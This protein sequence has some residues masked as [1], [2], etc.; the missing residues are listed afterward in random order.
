MILLVIPLGRSLFASNI[1]HVGRSVGDE[2]ISPNT[3][4]PLQPDAEQRRSR[5]RSR[6][7]YDLALGVESEAGKIDVTID[8]ST[9]I[10]S[11]EPDL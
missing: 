8:L 6:N 1:S 11:S 5:I 7:E 9:G 4:R 3:T 2:G 10:G